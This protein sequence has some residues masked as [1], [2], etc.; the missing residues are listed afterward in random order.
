MARP[1]DKTGRNRG[2]PTSTIGSFIIVG[3]VF[4]LA[5]T[6]CLFYTLLRLKSQGPPQTAWRL[7][8]LPTI[9]SFIF[10][11]VVLAPLPGMLTGQHDAPFKAFFFSAAQVYL[12]LG[13]VGMH[14]GPVGTPWRLLE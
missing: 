6:Q 13:P 10:A 2:I 11:A 5:G 14:G 7:R 9:T 12:V 1:T 8:P 3:Y 4:G